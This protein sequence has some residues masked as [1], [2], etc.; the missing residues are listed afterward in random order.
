[1]PWV[2]SGPNI[3]ELQAMLES[4]RD[5]SEPWEGRNTTFLG[6]II[7]QGRVK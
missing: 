6:E 4:N 2:S 7:G 1:M 3:L 5:V